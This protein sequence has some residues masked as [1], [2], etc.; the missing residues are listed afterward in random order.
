MDEQS[1]SLLRKIPGVDHV[2]EAAHIHPGLTNVPAFVLTSAV[3]Q[4]LDDLRRDILSGYGTV[5]ESDLNDQRIIAAVERIAAQTLA[6][7]LKRTVNATG[8]V[9]HTNLG[10]S[11]LAPAAIDNVEVVAGR[12]SNLEYDLQ[13]GKRGLRYTAVEQVI[14]DISGAE[15]A[16]VVNNNAGAVLLTLDTLARGKRVIVSRELRLPDT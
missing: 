10:R 9:V 13:T 12:Y 2:L 14:C 15:A 11:C 8:I 16:M 7:K 4:V 1:K 5:S 3:R 6:P